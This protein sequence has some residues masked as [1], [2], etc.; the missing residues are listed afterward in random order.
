MEITLTGRG[1]EITEA[2]KT[3]IHDK[4]AKIERHSLPILRTHVIL[5]VENHIRQE[6][7]ANVHVAGVDINAKGEDTDMYKALDIMVDKLDGQVRKHKEKI[8]GR[9]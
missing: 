6:V 9:R 7:E 8:T 3:L 2:I 5:S 4:L 1:I